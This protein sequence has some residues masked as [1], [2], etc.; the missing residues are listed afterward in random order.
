MRRA[1]PGAGEHRD[2]KLGDHPHVDPDRGALI[3]AELPERVGEPDDLGLEI[4]ERDRPPLVF[5]L[6][7]PVVGDLVA[8]P[9]LDVPVDAVV[10]DV[11]LAADVPLRVRQL[12]LAELFEVLEPGDAFAPL[13]LP[14]LVEVLVVDLRRCVGLRGEVRWRRVAPLLEQDRLDRGPG[15]GSRS[16]G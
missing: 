9:G 1:E 6:P 4:G 2:R 15:Q 7:L 10:R 5:R 14:E 12:P 16:Y 3:G 13:G 8:V 11:Q